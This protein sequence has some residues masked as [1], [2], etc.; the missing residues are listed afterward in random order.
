MHVLPQE[1]TRQFKMPA[2]TKLATIDS[3][4]KSLQDKHV[5]ALVRLAMHELEQS[6]I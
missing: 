2:N 5:K 6:I 4:L 1:V 3:E